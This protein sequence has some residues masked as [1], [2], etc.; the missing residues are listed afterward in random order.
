[1]VSPVLVPGA[2]RPPHVRR[3]ASPPLCWSGQ[4]WNRTPCCR[5][6]RSA[7]LSSRRRAAGA[8]RS[9]WRRWPSVPLA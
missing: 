1:M 8:S 6:R 3:R 2:D 5:C 7:P 9:L 4:S